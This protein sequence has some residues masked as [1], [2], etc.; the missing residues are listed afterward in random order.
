M[1]SQSEMQ[2]LAAALNRE[3]FNGSKPAT[4]KTVRWAGVS[5]AGVVAVAAYAHAELLTP[6]MMEDARDVAEDVVETHERLGSHENAATR[7]YVDLNLV[8]LRQQLNR[9]E[10]TQQ[11]ILEKVE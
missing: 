4:A 10:S 1:L 6:A 2:Q 11:L 5:L 7:E 9:M 8:P 3:A